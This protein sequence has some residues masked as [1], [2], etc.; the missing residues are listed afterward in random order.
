MGL[1]VVP[2]LP[3]LVLTSADGMRTARLR[4]L[5]EAGLATDADRSGRLRPVLAFYDAR[6]G[7]IHLP[8]GWTGATPAEQ[9]IL[10]HEMVHHF[11]AKTG[12]RF[13]CPE[14]REKAAFAAQ[15]RW[16]ERSGLTL[17]GAFRINRMFRV[18]VTNCFH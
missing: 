1:E 12:Q 5:R 3:R 2:D 10:V 16:L 15:A 11:Q 13:A 4:L 8:A 9:S 17:E 7:V 14:E 18:M 6:H